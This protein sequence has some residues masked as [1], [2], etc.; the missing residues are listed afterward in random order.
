MTL[1]RLTRVLHVRP[2]TVKIKNT[3]KTI[4]NKVG[5]TLKAGKI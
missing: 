1:L 4:L 3:N 2:Y 5:F